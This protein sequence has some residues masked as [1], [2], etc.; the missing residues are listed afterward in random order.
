LI[1]GPSQNIIADSSFY[2]CFLTD[3]EEPEILDRV[4]DKFD[5]YI[6][7]L[8]EHEIKIDDYEELKKNEKIIRVGDYINFGEILKPFF[9]TKS[10]EKGEHEVIGLGYHF[11]MI[12]MPFYLVIDDL[13]AREFVKNNANHLISFLHGTVGIIV[14]CCCR[15]KIF[16]KDESMAIINKIGDSKFRIS[17]HILEKIKTDI[18]RC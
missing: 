4:I 2:I 13:E 9:S 11:F 14:L 10:I 15:F 5:F 6:T 8:V 3:I 18:E 16:S 1:M 17:K 7:P 12:G